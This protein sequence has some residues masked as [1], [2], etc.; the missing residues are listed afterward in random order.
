MRFQWMLVLGL[1]AAIGAAGSDH[2]M[3]AGAGEAEVG[4]TIGLADAGTATSIAGDSDEKNG[5]ESK[6]K[7][8]NG[9]RRR[10]AND[11]RR[12]AGNARRGAGDAR[13]GAGN[14]GGDARRGANRKLDAGVGSGS[15]MADGV[16][17]MQGA[18]SKLRENGADERAAQ[19]EKRLAEMKRRMEELR[20]K[21][22]ARG[23]GGSGKN[24]RQGGK[25]MRNGRGDG[26]MKR[27]G[28]RSFDG[29]GRMRGGRGRGGAP[30]D[31]VR[32]RDFSAGSPGSGF[33]VPFEGRMR[34]PEGFGQPQRRFGGQM[35]SRFEGQGARDRGALKRGMGS[36][37]KPGV[38]RRGE[39]QQRRNNGAD[40][41]DGADKA[42]R[43]KRRNGNTDS[44]NTDG[45]RKRRE[46]D[47][48]RKKRGGGDGGGGDDGGAKADA[49]A[50]DNAVVLIA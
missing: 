40:K 44:G 4:E 33:S 17:R 50:L 38:M 48:R 42:D 49:E 46:N 12:S 3:A 20:K 34:F 1:T 30:I 22:A 2:V 7:A 9:D 15:P 26:S 8:K 47:D 32:G 37:G 5:T 14:R 16:R 6:G 43:K 18:I 23:V 21:M 10:G 41:T 19:L 45:E 36:S 28:A 31:G 35:K 13:R 27:W 29:E 11:A 25:N 39:M 24:D